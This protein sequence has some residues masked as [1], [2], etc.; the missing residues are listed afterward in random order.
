MAAAVGLPGDQEGKGGGNNP[1]IQRE[2]R[3]NRVWEGVVHK[4]GG[5]RGGTHAFR[6]CFPPG[7]D[8]GQLGGMSY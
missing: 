4:G 1:F 5:G 2:R 3:G 7:A 8:M 6:V